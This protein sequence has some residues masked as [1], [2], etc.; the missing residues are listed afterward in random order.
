MIH[1]R[2]EVVKNTKNAVEE[3]SLN[4]LNSYVTGL[5]CIERTETEDEI[6]DCTTWRSGLFNRFTD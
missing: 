1:A 3:S 2:V 5:R 4:H 6:I